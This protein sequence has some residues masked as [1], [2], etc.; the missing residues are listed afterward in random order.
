MG[1]IH[2]VSRTH[3]HIIMNT[4]VLFSL[5]LAALCVAVQGRVVRVLRQADQGQKFIP[6]A[7]R[8][9]GLPAVPVYADEKSDPG[10]AAPHHKP[11]QVGPV[12]TFVKT[13]PYANFKWGVRHVAGV[14]YGRR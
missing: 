7:L 1:S 12:Y 14:Q 13:D 2:S 4:K 6:Q 11:G 8:H 9:D 5:I 3:T 10:Y